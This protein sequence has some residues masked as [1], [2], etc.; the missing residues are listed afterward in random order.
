M[1]INSSSFSFMLVGMEFGTKAIQEDSNS[2]F[3]IARRSPRKLFFPPN[4]QNTSDLLFFRIRND[5]FWTA[6]RESV[7][8]VRFFFF[9]LIIEIE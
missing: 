8:M 5:L 9:F 2:H 4:R 1:Y 3:T 6:S 7:F